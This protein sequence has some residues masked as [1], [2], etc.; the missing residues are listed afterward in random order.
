MMWGIYSK[1][2]DWRDVELIHFDKHGSFDSALIISLILSLLALDN[3]Q[4]LLLA[5]QSVQTSLLLFICPLLS[6]HP[7]FSLSFS[8]SWV[9]SYVWLPFAITLFNIPLFAA[10]AVP[11]PPARRWSVINIFVITQ[12][13]VTSATTLKFLASCN[14]VPIQISWLGKD[15]AIT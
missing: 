11:P 10:L 7:P 5:A 6:P 15:R 4:P 12:G 8:P 13:R 2:C 9:P 14:I 1:L 3:I